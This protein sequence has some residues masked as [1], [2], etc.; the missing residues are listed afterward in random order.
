MKIILI[1]LSGN[2][3]KTTLS[4]NMFA[5]LIGA[6]RISIED[7]N[8]DGEAVDI[9]ISAANFKNL[10]AEIYM[11]DDDMNFVVDIGASNAKAMFKMF[12]QLSATAALFD[13]WI[14]PVTPDTKHSDALQ[15]AESLENVGI[16][17]DKIAFLPTNVRDISTYESD[18]S[19]ILAAREFGFFVPN[20]A[21]LQTEAV[22]M[23][24]RE[25]RNII[26]VAKTNPDF[27][28]MKAELKRASASKEEEIKL[29]KEFVLH[30]MCQSAARNIQ[31]VFNEL[32]FFKQASKKAVKNG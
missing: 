22:S 10:A 1:N 14:I 16:S 12:D 4:K 20:N 24:W 17:K 2:T 7:T 28:K 25:D 19:T 26:D 3:G 15:T 11:A 8:D 6:K 5:P 32:P 9:T 31:S 29:G 21:V 23:L 18:F 27:A 30:A 13:A